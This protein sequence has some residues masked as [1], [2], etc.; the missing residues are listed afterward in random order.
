MAEVLEL[1]SLLIDT[2]YLLIVSSQPASG[3]VVISKPTVVAWVWFGYHRFLVNN[4]KLY[5]PWSL[6]CI[7]TIGSQSRE[8]RHLLRT[9]SLRARASIRSECRYTNLYPYYV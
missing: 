9:R 4:L 5:Q 7:S 3:C 6:I 2:L 8:Q 1:I